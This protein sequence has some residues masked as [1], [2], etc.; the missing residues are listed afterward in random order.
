[1]LAHMGAQGVLGLAPHI[2]YIAA[3]HF[4]SM[5]GILMDLQTAFG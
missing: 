5:E 4:F 3:E 2:T 1:M